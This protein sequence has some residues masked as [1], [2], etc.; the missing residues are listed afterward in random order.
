[1]YYA[2]TLV[3]LIVFYI[4]GILLLSK[5]Q[6]HQKIINFIFSITVALIYMYCLITIYISVGFN[7]WNF[8]N[9]LPTANVSPFT[10]TL[11]IVSFLFP[12]KIRYHVLYL[13][14]LLS[15]AMFCAG[16]LSCVSYILRHYKF[17]LN[18]AMDAFVHVVLSLYGV[19]IVK[20][21]Q[22]KLNEKKDAIISGC[23]ILGVAA[24]MLVINL[25]FKTAFF[26]L[27]MYGNHSIY[28]IVVVDNGIVSAIIYFIGL[29]GVLV[30]GY[31][32]QVL[33]SKTKRIK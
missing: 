9:A 10:Y 32:Y 19:Y 26:G 2:V 16:A 12:K 4:F 17:H 29:S 33:L 24:F 14:S 22:I 3:F 30:A 20:S 6:N 7:D 28:N 13:I 25:I 5:M 8:Q 15:F 21:K 23:L 31:Y 27:S 18:I 1:M 11:V